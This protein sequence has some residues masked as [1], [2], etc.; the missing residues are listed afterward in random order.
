MHVLG[1][2]IICNEILDF[3]FQ[4]LQSPC[5]L[6]YAPILLHAPN[7]FEA[8]RRV[9]C[10]RQLRS[11]LWASTARNRLWCMFAS[12]FVT[13]FASILTLIFDRCLVD[14]WSQNG[15]AKTLWEG[16][17]GRG[18]FFGTFFGH[19][20][21]DAF[22]LLLGSILSPVWFHLAPF[23][24]PF[25]PFWSSWALI[26]FQNRPSWRRVCSKIEFWITQR[27]KLQQTWL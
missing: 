17:G 19:W 6:S 3:S 10:R 2:I 9:Y 12:I 16:G 21:W 22:W 4:K 25:A 7:L 18:T 11:A 15:L 20:F 1:L 24:H 23:G 5:R 8:R 13:F 27:C 26:W 14:C